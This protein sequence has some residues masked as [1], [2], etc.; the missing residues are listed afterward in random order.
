M[1]TLKESAMAYEM[2]TTLNIA[3]LE[4]VDVNLDVKEETHKKKDS[5]EEF[6]IKVVEIEG[7]KYRVPASVLQGMK[8]II[9]RV[10]E[11]KHVSVIKNGSGM[12]SKYQ[13][14]PYSKK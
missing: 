7:K 10:P 14:L 12:N 4:Y 9:E 6:T 3:D 2:P 13:V 11:T 5:D 8:A 1:A